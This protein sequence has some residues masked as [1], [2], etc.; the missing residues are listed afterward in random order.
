M[1]IFLPV[2]TTIGNAL[3]VPAIAAFIGNI[4]AN[5]LTTFTTLFGRK[6]ALN[7][8]VIALIVGITTAAYVALWAISE[9]I[10]YATPPYFEQAVSLVVPDNFKFCVSSLFAAHL[11]RWAWEWQFFAIVRMAR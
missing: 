11:T 7:L 9:A 4:A 1:A 6:V 2:L 8:T 3:R 5:I 10:Y